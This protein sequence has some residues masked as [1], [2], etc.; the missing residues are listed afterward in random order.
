MFSDKYL[1]G[2][3]EDSDVYCSIIHSPGT[4]QAEEKTYCKYNYQTKTNV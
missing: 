1:D 4:G 2:D 3:N